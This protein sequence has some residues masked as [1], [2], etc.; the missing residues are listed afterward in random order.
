[1]AG[2]PLLWRSMTE[3]DI[4]GVVTVARQSFPDH[5]ESRACFENRLAICPAMSF[6]LADADDAVRGY[7]FAYP[8]KGETAP[9]LNTL[10]EAIPA[11]ADR[12]YLH[13]LALDPAVRGGGHTRAI[14]ERLI[15][16]ARMDGWTT[17]ALVAVNDA[18]AFWQRM[19]FHPATSPALAAKLAS[20]GDDARYMVRAI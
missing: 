18:T 15:D 5:F 12:I 1:M 8:W 4:H 10:I 6:V 14:V 20:Y 16:Q 13:D 3:A 17:M 9:P 2:A 11:D 7:L 19:G